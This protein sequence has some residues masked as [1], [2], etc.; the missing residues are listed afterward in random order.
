MFISTFF[1]L[2]QPDSQLNV[3]VKSILLERYRKISVTTRKKNFNVKQCHEI[4]I[5]IVN[6]NCKTTENLTASASSAGI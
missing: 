2:A 6:E 4:I 3:L 5:S 1:H